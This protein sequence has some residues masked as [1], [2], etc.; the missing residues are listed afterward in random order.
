MSRV[1][2]GVF[3]LE[4]PSEYYG[5]PRFMNRSSLLLAN[6][7]CGFTL[8]LRWLRPSQVWMPAYL[9]ESMFKIAESEAGRMRLYPV[10]ERLAA[11]DRRWLQDV[12]PG[13]VVV[14]VD[15][16]GFVPDAE[17][18]G[19]ARER[20]AIVVEDAS[21]ALLSADAGSIGDYVL[22][23]PRKFAGLPDG[24]AL[25]AN[26]GRLPEL[27]AAAG[28]QAWWNLAY[29]ACLRRRQ[30]EEGGPREWLPVHQQAEDEHPSE[31]VAMSEYSR[32][33][34]TGLDWEAI[35]R[36]RSANYRVLAERLARFD[37]MPAASAGTVPV[38]FTM[39]V[40]NRDEVR[41]ALFAQDIF[42]SRL[43][44]TAGRVPDE[45]VASHRLS[46]TTMTLHC[47]QRYDAEDMARTADIVLEKA[48]P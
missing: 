34:A 4:S 18:A 16:F 40:D 32:N 28:E 14:V 30:F 13:D 2:G 12:R 26:N 29:D 17:L 24:G 5:T 9:C 41:A 21:H 42:P 11:S 38:G 47:D 36:R 22:W 3:A 7:R 37:Q 6:A 19:S 35:A 46:A 33:L 31:P 25:Q 48:R 15:Y 1:I 39:R 44:P 20:G 8:L 45:F 10:D 23:S 27:V 43:W